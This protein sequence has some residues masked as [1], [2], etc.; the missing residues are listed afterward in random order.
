MSDSNKYF[1]V[2]EGD[3]C[4]WDGHGLEQRHF[5]HIHHAVRFADEASARCVKH[6]LLA[7]F[8]VGLRVTQ[9]AWMEPSDER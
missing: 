4:Y 9:H 3:G 5:S 8:S 7:A 1:W 2:I 6:W